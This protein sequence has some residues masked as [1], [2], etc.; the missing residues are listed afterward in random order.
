MKSGLTS[1]LCVFA[2]AQVLLA[3]AAVKPGVVSAPSATRPFSFVQKA[4]P[5]LPS[6]FAA[7][8]WD[9]EV[10]VT[11]GSVDLESVGREDARRARE[12]KAFRIGIVRDFP[13]EVTLAAAKSRVGQWVVLDDGS[14]VWRL[15]VRSEGAVGVRV[16]LDGVELPAGGELSVFATEDPTQTRGPYTSAGLKGRKAFWTGAVF[17]GCVTLECHV[18]AGVSPGQVAFRVAKIAHIYR[19]PTRVAKEGSC[20]NDVTCFPAWA[21][22]ANGV[23]GIGSFNYNDYIWCTGCLLNDL[24][25]STWVDYFMTANHCVGNQSEADDTE[26]YWFFQTATCNGI[27]PNIASVQTTDGGADY[28]AGQV[29]FPGSDFAFLRLREP[30]PGGVSYRGWTTEGP[31]GSETLTC[32]H[33]PDGNYKR[34]S[35]CT[36]DDIDTNYW[37]VKYSSGVTE[38]GSSGA[39]LFNASG[40]FIGQLYGGQSSCANPA[41]TDDFGRFD[42]AYGVIGSWLRGEGSPPVPCELQDGM[43]SSTGSYDAFLYGERDFGGELLPAVRGTFSLTVSSLSGR[44]TAKA[45]LQGRTLGFTGKTWSGVESDGTWVSEV[46]AM[47]GETLT[48]FVRQGSVWG[49]LR[50]GSL[51]SETLSVEGTRN[52]FSGSSS[53]QAQTAL[54]RFLGYYTVALPAVDGRS[55]GA[56]QAAPEGS[57]YL[58][59]TIGSRG[60]VKLAGVMADGTKVSQASRLILFDECGE[61]ACVPFFVPLYGRKGWTGALFWITP[62][63]RTVFTDWDKDWFVRWEKPGAGPDGFSEL[64]VPCGGYYNPYA[65]LAAHYRLSAASNS[66]PY[67]YSG[68]TVL[69]QQDALPRWVGVTVNRQKMAVVAGARPVLTGTTYDYSGENPSLA[70]L[71]FASRTGI[72]KGRF[73]LY[74]DDV[75]NGR[76]THKQVKVS[77]AGI[78]TQA[79]DAAFTGWPEGQGMYLVPDSDPL[80]RA[81]RLKRSFGCDLYLAP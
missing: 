70:T 22:A 62:G 67:Y 7:G 24:D 42:V 52:R 45:V 41:G 72:Y 34:I 6:S 76:L 19:D 73:N 46:Q 4:L 39:P 55:S 35:F 80:F 10:H 23:A 63:V 78:L 51:V 48:L 53:T 3:S 17:S 50:G 59:V 12:G 9:S 65:L 74:Y 14:H 69:P 64:L 32:I 26:F 5:A 44:Y 66:V 27:P 47:G 81:Y 1:K 29:Y 2:S 36:L 37:I 54:T 20:H 79:R 61:W 57:G 16:R 28:L 13:E 30:P 71:S 31:V 21:E 11:L 58:T 43:L 68:G 38:A 40:E 8:L 25:N 60:S 33:H 75:L 49:A 56:A 18:P 77:Y 15:T